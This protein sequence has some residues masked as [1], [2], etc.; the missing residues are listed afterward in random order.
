MKHT[1]PGLCAGALSAALLL[2][3]CGKS[4]PASGVL[5]GTFREVSG[6]SLTTQEG[7]TLTLEQLRGKVWIANFVFTSCAAECLVLSSRLAELQEEF[8][9]F[10]DVAFVSFSV[11]P[12]TDTPARLRTYAER[13]RADPERWFF[14]T[15]EAAQ[16]DKIAVESFLVSVSREGA[17]TSSGNLLHSNKI[18]LVD[19]SGRVRAYVEGLPRESLY[20]LSQIVAQLRREPAPPPEAP[21]S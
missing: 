8:R 17:E 3:S 2:V 14:L 12:Q 1:L 16:I 20:S 19:R 21:R 10:D 5:A 13:W 18:A 9:G 15:G 11:D 7:E 4:Q 6:F